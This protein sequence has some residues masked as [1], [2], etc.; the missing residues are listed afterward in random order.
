MFP[1]NLSETEIKN[2]IMKSLE[3]GTYKGT[4]RNGD[5]SYVYSINKYGINQVKVIVNKDGVIKT[6]YPLSG[7]KSKVNL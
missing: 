3:K 4:A 1:K 6:D 7:N 2:I 5:K